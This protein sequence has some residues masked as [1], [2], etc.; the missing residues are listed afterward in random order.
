VNWIEIR[1]RFS[2]QNE[3][4]ILS[5]RCVM[6]LQVFKNGQTNVLQI[7]SDQGVRPCQLVM[8]D[9]DNSNNRKKLRHADLR[10]EANDSQQSERQLLHGSLLL[11]EIAHFTLVRTPREGNDSGTG[12]KALDHS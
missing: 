12:M 2:A 11:N 8:T 1:K 4:N 7:H 6:W 3:D 5:P 9:N 10:N